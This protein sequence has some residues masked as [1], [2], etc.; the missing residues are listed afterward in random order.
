[1]EVTRAEEEVVAYRRRITRVVAPE[2]LSGE[3][4]PVP[5]YRYLHLETRLLEPLFEI[6]Q[7]MEVLYRAHQA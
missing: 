2:N 7:E 5:S 6:G 1:M 3:S 4:K